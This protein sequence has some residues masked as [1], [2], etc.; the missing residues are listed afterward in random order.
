MI[1]QNDKEHDK[2]KSISD[3]K[4]K[5]VSYAMYAAKKKKKRQYFP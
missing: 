3:S 1:L 2:A 4:S 5:I